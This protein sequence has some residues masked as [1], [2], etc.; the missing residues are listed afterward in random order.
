M[1]ENL[2]GKG[3]EKLA[4]G[5]VWCLTCGRYELINAKWLIWESGSVNRWPKCH[6]ETMSLDSPEERAALKQEQP[7]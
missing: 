2:N 5:M 4:R 6:G 1:A 7:A 3:K